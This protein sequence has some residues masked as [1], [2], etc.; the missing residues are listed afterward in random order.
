[1]Q[2]RQPLPATRHQGVCL[3]VTEVYIVEAGDYEQRCIMFVA[4]SI[5][6]VERKLKEDHPPPYIVSWRRELNP[7]HPDWCPTIIG[8]FELV[9]GLSIKHTQRY[10]VSVYDV[11]DSDAG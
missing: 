3:R 2:P 9:G 1:M 4:A 6:D 11:E 10:E 7:R 5:E 8:D